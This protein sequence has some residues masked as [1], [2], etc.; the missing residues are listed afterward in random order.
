MRESKSYRDFNIQTDRK[1]KHRRPD[2]VVV[3]KEKNE[4]TII[5]LANPSDHN[6]AQK[7]FQKLD[8]YSEL[9]LKAARMWIK[10]TA[11][12]PIIIGALSTVYQRIYSPT[13]NN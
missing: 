11:V 4:C 10:K 3:N 5:D 13:S 9:R 8:I 12:V 1:I 6:L 7:K 2:V